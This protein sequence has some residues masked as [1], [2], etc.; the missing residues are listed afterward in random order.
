[1]LKIITKFSFKKN[2]S[3]CIYYAIHE[4]KSDGTKRLSKD[5]CVIACY[6]RLLY[7]DVIV[8]R[9]NFYDIR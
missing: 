8:R 3:L 6:M 1:M 9:F 7:D 2:Q 4:L 5:G